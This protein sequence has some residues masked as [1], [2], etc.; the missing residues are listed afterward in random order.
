MMI[1]NVLILLSL[2]LWQMQTLVRQ[3]RSARA[4]ISKLTQRIEEKEAIIKAQRRGLTVL[5]FNI[6]LRLNVRFANEKLKIQV[7][8]LKKIET[9]I[10]DLKTFESS[11]IRNLPL[12]QE[13]LENVK[14]FVV[15][16]SNRLKF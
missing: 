1:P 7:E 12:P 8:K 10:K 6:N 3:R 5:S 2:S 16:R 15:G 11:K 13:C 14:Q 4:K 9:A